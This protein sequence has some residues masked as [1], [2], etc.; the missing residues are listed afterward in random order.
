MAETTAV[1]RVR[2]DESTKAQ[3]AETLAAMGLTISDAVRVFLAC[4]AT[5]KELPFLTKL[6]NATHHVTEA[7]TGGT[8][9]GH[10]ARFAASDPMIDDICGLC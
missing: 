5:D 4:I 2:V 6:R 8:I 10:R 3:A 9:D 1:V 7:G